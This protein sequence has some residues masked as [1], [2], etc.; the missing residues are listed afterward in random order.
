MHNDNDLITVPAMESA[1][2]KKNELEAKYGGDDSWD[3]D[4]TVDGRTFHC[5][6]RKESNTVGRDWFVHVDNACWDSVGSMDVARF[7]QIER[8]LQMLCD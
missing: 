8:F 2:W 1:G 6:L 3:K 4:Y 7:S 5:T